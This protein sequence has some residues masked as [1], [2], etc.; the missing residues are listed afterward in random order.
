M[1]LA[2]NTLIVRAKVKKITKAAFTLNFFIR[3]FLRKNLC[4][5]EKNIDSYEAS[6]N[7]RKKNLM[8]TQ[9]NK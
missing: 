2:I 8:W 9:L 4:K 7:L 3:N 1:V 5:N 6:V